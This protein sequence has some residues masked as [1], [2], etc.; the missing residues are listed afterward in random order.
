[1]A[2]FGRAESRLRKLL[3]AVLLVL[4]ACAG[5][6]HLSQQAADHPA[7]GDGRLHEVAPGVF[8]HRAFASNA[9]VVFA[10]ETVFLV[11][12]HASV[13]AGR[14]LKQAVARLT[15]HPTTHLFLTGP[16][17]LHAAGAAT[18]ENVELV[19]TRSAAN[20]MADPTT[21]SAQSLELLGL[22]RRGAGS[23]PTPTRVVNDRSFLQLDRMDVEIRDVATPFAPGA[24][25]VWLPERKVLFAGDALTTVGLPWTGE[26]FADTAIDAHESWKA[27]FDVIRALR[28]EVLVPAHGPALFGEMEIADRVD[29]VT[30]VL[31]AAATT[32]LSTDS[33]SAEEAVDVVLGA[34]TPVLAGLNLDESLLSRHELARA[35][36]AST[37]DGGWLT[38]SPPALPKVARGDALKVLEGSDTQSALTRTRNLVARNDI[39]L[40]VTVIEEQLKR[41]PTAS[42]FNGLLADVLFETA[43][44]HDTAAGAA[45]A[46]ARALEAARRELALTPR[47]P[48]A[49][50]TLGCLSTWGAAVTGESM[51]SAIADVERALASGE[52]DRRHQR[53]AKWCLARAHAIAGRSD[54]ADA[55]LRAWLPAPA[56]F[57][58]ALFAP[59][60]RALP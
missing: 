25:L 39:A 47:E 53:R 57:A 38:V 5:V 17:A 21:N 4:L 36:V 23:V 7:V 40:A 35:V 9:G 12:A 43:K 42:H 20:A 46:A 60:M 58:F 31:D 22:P 56:R 30:R 24:T 18:F 49:T 16:E 51:Q 1:M 44:A 6:W 52:L 59:R 8:V 2:A 54:D 41:T 11:D 19:A 15:P 3:P 32:A 14:A 55:W 10:G 28:P 33:L 27:A 34:L 26:V 37:R 45:T 50:L 29:V 13:Q 48:L